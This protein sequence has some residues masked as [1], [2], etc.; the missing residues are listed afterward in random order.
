[1][2]NHASPDQLYRN[3]K[4][5]HSKI[6]AMEITAKDEFQLN[7]VKILRELV[8]GQIHSLE[9]FGHHKKAMDLLMIEIFQSRSAT[10][11]GQD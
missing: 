8:Q 9:E 3:L 6:N 1:M 10:Y 11:G 4:D 5:I 2:A 7:V